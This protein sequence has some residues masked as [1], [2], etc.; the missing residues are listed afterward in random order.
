MLRKTLSG[1]P[2]ARRAFSS[3]A[4]CRQVELGVDNQS[5]PVGA[6][7]ILPSLSIV[8][9]SEN[10][11]I[12]GLFSDS[13]LKDIWTEQTAQKLDD[14]KYG[15][16]ESPL[17]STLE[18]AFVE[19]NSNK[20]VF[21]KGHKTS[22]ANL[23]EDFAITTNNPTIDKYYKLLSKTAK[24]PTEQFVFQ[25]ASAIYNL[26]YFLSSLK[27]NPDN[28]VAK[29]GVEELYKTPDVFSEIKNA[30]RPEFESQIEAS[31]GSLQE[32]KTL[33]LSTAKAVKGNGYTWLVYKFRQPELGQE[34]RDLSRFSSLAILNTY[35]HGTPHHFRA[36]QISN[37][38]AFKKQKSESSEEDDGSFAMYKID[39]P[40][41]EQAQDTYDPLKYVY[42][43][44]MAIGNN[45]SFYLRDYGVFGKASYLE[46]VWN[47]IDW[48][49]VETRWA[50]RAL[51]TRR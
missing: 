42:E 48:S 40:S 24:K 2:I 10:T 21:L 13:V 45:P 28:T 3:R 27:P 5:E 9:N 25:N 22:A 36:G 8:E 19:Y 14:L 11:G 4:A 39:I 17:R 1:L 49:V 15:I 16:S 31:F 47:C 51:S 18:S 50:N 38:R 46:N 33:L 32:F 44:L 34:T 43:P 30:P 7:I 12:P 26:Y 35:N 20:N 37:A 41:L 29:V 6:T 23:M